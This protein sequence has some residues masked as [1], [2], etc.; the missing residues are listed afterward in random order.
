ME[1]FATARA[2]PAAL[3]AQTAAPG[4]GSAPTLGSAG[5][6][7]PTVEAPAVDTSGVAIVGGAFHV[8]SAVADHDDIGEMLLAS[9]VSPGFAGELIGIL[10]AGD[11]SDEREQPAGEAAADPALQTPREKRRRGAAE[12]GANITG[13][14]RMAVP[15]LKRPSVQQM[16]QA[17]WGRS[18]G[19]LRQANGASAEVSAMGLFCQCVSQTAG[20]AS[21]AD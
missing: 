16:Q 7:P 14:L 19:R 12:G 2:A 17:L 5:G 6:D 10:D 11:V 21:P 3:P 20:H 1:Q 13:S 4:A 9:G 15:V 18:G 8:D